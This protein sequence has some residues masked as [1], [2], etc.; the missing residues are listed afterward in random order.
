MYFHCDLSLR[1][2]QVT[3]IFIVKFSITWLRIS[4]I[5]NEVEEKGYSKDP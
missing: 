5:L 3:L 2:I 4:K 1:T